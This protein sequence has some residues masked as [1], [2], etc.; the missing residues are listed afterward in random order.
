MKRFPFLLLD[1][2]PIIKLFELNLWDK[3]I[4]QCEVTISRIIAEYQVRYTEDGISHIDLRTYTEKKLIHV[5][6]EDLSTVREFIDKFD[7]LYKAEIHDGEKETLAFLDGSPEKWL[8]CSSD[9][10]V[11]KVLGLLRKGEQGI[12]L[13]EVLTKIELASCIN[14]N[15]ITP[16]NKDW[17]YSKKFRVKYTTLGQ[18]DDI[19]GRGLA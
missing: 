19:Q 2:G 5:L 1:A 8:V 18:I 6:E 14:W 16:K 11:Y 7:S 17:K 3:F 9:H 10:V 12:S 13:E 15:N 4:T